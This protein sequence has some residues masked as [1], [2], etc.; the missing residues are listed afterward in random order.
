M[1][2]EKKQQKEIEEK[3]IDNFRVGEMQPERDHQ[4]TAS[5]KSYVSDALGVNGREARANNYF[6]FQMKVEPKAGTGTA[7]CLLISA[8][9]KTG[10]LIF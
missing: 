10:S 5:E 7:C 8:M 9:I 1:R 6:S 4:L 2:I 3:T